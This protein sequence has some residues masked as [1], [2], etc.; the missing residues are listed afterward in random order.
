MPGVTKTT[1]TVGNISVLGGPIPGL[2]Q[3]APYAVDAYFAYI[4]SKGGVNGRQLKLDS[5]DDAYSCPQNKAQTEA[6]KNK[7][8]ALVGDFSVFDNC[9]V[10]T[11]KANPTFPDVSA[12]I[13][14]P[15]EYGLPNV[16]S[17]SPSV[18]GGAAGPLRWIKANYPNTTK[19]GTMITNNPGAIESFNRNG[20]PLLKALGFDLVYSRIYNATETDFTSDIIRMRQK[21]VNFIYTPSGT[22]QMY[23]RLLAAGA[24]Q[25]YH[26]LSYN[27]SS[28]T[29]AFAQL[30]PGGVGEGAIGYLSTAPFLEGP[31]SSIPSVQLLNEWMTKTHPKTV[32]DSYAASGWA[33][34]ALF[35]QALTQAGPN[36]TRQ[37]LLDALKSM[38]SFNA[39]GFL[40]TTDVGG[41]Q[42]VTCYLMVQ[43]KGGK[44]VTVGTP[45]PTGFQCDPGG[46]YYA[47]QNKIVG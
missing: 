44:W 36:P 13:A 40:P 2:F 11:L 7:V 43:Y 24:Q 46:Y 31:T 41:K 8:F 14:D 26:P 30:A 4:N 15:T 18:P 19:V 45:G 1:V 3:N 42:P 38:H 16:Y 37:K 39:G 29:N 5:E 34:A 23:G 35:V 20:K 25:N 6:L 33:N 10:P 12:V 28:Y 17:A 21:G 22:P 47:Q 32:I 9:G 27:G